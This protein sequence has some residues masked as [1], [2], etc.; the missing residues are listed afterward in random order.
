MPLPFS[1]LVGKA[2][3]IINSTPLVG[4]AMNMFN[5]ALE[6]KLL[7]LLDT[8][9]LTFINANNSFD[10]MPMKSLPMP[11]M[12]TSLGDLAGTVSTHLVPPNPCKLP[13]A[14]LMKAGELQVQLVRKVVSI[15]VEPVLK[16]FTSGGSS[17]VPYNY[18][19]KEKEVKGNAWLF[20]NN[21]NNNNFLL[22][23]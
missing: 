10:F 14:I 4:K 1:P 22:N 16:S 9:G 23:S 12:A 8:F 3:N 18:K 11:G 7:E 13:L 6:R 17:I 21:N 19:E 5:S 20:H 2:V 15:T